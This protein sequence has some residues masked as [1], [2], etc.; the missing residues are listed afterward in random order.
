MGFVRESL[1]LLRKLMMSQHSPAA[2][3]SPAELNG[4][5]VFGGAGNCGKM[6]TVE[7]EVEG[8]DEKPF[9]DRPKHLS[10][11][12]E[13]ILRRPAGLPGQKL[14]VYPQTP[15]DREEPTSTQRTVCRS[16]HRRVRTTFTV[17]QLEELERV[18]QDT[19]YPDVNTRDL[20]ATRTQLSEGKVQIWFQN[21]RA[22]WRRTEARGGNVGHL[23]PNKSKC[24]HLLTPPLFFTP[25]QNFALQEQ[26]HPP[27]SL[28][29]SIL[30]YDSS[31]QKLHPY[32][33]L[34]QIQTP[35]LPWLPCLT[36]PPL[37]KATS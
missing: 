32:T 22:K 17:S 27:V 12:I 26:P 15:A 28:Y 24:V 19:Q 13:D 2:I 23:Q 16:S 25:V 34:Q 10:H 9:R 8:V 11:S 7:V 3:S 21:R 18:F 14:S 5:R 35:C 20:L 30:P 31:S 29:P 37:H 6:L 33:E 4:G 1:L 36:P